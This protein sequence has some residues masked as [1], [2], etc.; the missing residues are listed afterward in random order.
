MG[1][2]SDIDIMRQEGAREAG[3]FEAFGYDRETAEAM[4]EV[5]QRAET[6]TREARLEAAVRL[7]L[8]IEYHSDSNLE[9]VKLTP[10]SRRQLQEAL[11]NE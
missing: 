10:K 4:A 9:T 3:D 11:K 2:M 6:P 5:V 7:I 1:I 8:A